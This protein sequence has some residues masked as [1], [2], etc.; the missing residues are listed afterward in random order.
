MCQPPVLALIDFSKPFTI[1]FDAFGVGLRAVLI[2]EILFPMR[3]Q[4][5]SLLREGEK[6]FA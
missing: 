6:R 5:V 2:Q 4:R 1:E 3:S